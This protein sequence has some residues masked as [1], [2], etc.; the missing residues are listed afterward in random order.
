M[1]ISGTHVRRVFGQENRRETA[2]ILGIGTPLP[3]FLVLLPGLLSMFPVDPLTGRSG[4]KTSTLL[5]LAIAA[6]VTSIPVISRIFYDL[7]ILHTRFASLILGFAMIE[8]IILWAVLAVATALA[9]TAVSQQ[10]LVNNIAT[11]VS[12]TVAYMT[13]GLLVAPRLLTRFHVSCWSA[14]HKSFALAYVISVLFAYIAIATLLEVNLIFAAFLAG[15]GVVGGM[16]GQG[17]CAFPKCWT[18]LSIF[19]R[20]YSS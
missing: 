1:F 16:E 17:E 7:K 12:I 3:F 13:F 11:H 18:R 9:K 20:R 10:S 5:I 8:D 19:Q 2:W 4:Q 15:F 6:A 14:L